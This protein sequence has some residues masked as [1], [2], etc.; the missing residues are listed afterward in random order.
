MK[1]TLSLILALL[2]SISTASVAFA[3]E[4]VALEEEVAVI[5]LSD[6]KKDISLLSN[7]L[8]I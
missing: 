1:K 6:R 5:L 7:K 8:L 4:E 2:M 3:T